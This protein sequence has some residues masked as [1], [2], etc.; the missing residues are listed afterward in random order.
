MREGSLPKLLALTH[1]ETSR[2]KSFGSLRKRGGNSPETEREEEKLR[3]GNNLLTKSFSSDKLFIYIVG[4]DTS[5]TLSR[6]YTCIR[7]NANIVDPRYL[8]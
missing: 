7:F 8:N 3:E 6:T 2:E 5:F 1:R 4:F